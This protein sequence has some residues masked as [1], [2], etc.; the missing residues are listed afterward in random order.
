MSSSTHFETLKSIVYAIL[1]ALLFRSFF[2][3]PFHIPS[4]SMRANLLVGDYLFV[5]KSAYG[6]SRY[7]FPFGLDLFDGRILSDDRP[8]RGDVV[9]FRKPGNE[10]VDFIKRV[11]GLPGDT[12]QMKKG[13][14]FINDTAIPKESAG[15]FRFF[16]PHLQSYVAIAQYQETLPSGKTYYVLDETQY[17]YGD[18][19]PLFT[20]PEKHYFM[21]GDNRDNSTD[22][23]FSTVGF[24]PEVNLVGQADLIGF[25]IDSDYLLRMERFFSWIR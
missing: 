14:L 10:T 7:S 24:V 8:E 19:T 3:E 4:G 1:L 16:D 23:R 2:F 11:I 13:I 6:Y 25:S 22:S 12:V 15:E 9:V 5:S 17:G 20:V 18:S 21:M